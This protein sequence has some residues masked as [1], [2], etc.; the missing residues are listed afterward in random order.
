MD[1]LAVLASFCK[2]KQEI[3]QVTVYLSDYGKECLAEEAKKGPTLF[4]KYGGGTTAEDRGGAGAPRDSEGRDSQQDTEGSDD[5]Q[6]RR[7]RKEGRA[8]GPGDG[9]GR[10]GRGEKKRR[11]GK[12]GSADQNG[13]FDPRQL[14]VYERSRLRY[15]YAIVECDSVATAANVY[16]E[17]NGL[18]LLRSANL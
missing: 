6:R 5:G 7:S 9:R 1:I 12:G 14:Q 18:E 2:P 3:K 15:Y 4:W 10:E 16:A 17:C 8:L 11:K 13:E